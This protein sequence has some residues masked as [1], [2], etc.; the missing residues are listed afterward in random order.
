M[1]DLNDVKLI[2][3]IVKDS[4]LEQTADIKYAKF[5]I[6]VNHDVKTENGN[7]E[8]VP[9]FVDLAIFNNYA[10][11]M[12]KFLKKGTLVLVQGFIKQRQWEKDGQKITSLGI[13]VNKI[14]LLSSFGL[15]LPPLFLLQ[16][17]VCKSS[18]GAVQPYGTLFLTSI[19]QVHA[20][21]ACHYLSA[22]YS[23]I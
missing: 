14:Q 10:E 3:R 1:T 11:K 21:V 18:K 7:W 19:C 17:Y 20:H 5:A 22:Y 16:D 6:A 2:G 23:E 15:Y 13:A 8:S 12:Y 4:V 9:T